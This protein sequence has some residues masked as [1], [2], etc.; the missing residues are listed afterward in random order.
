MSTMTVHAS[1]ACFPGYT[2]EDAMKALSA[3]VEEPLMGLLAVDQVQLC[4][5]NHGVLTGERLERLCQAYPDTRFRLHANCRVASGQPRWTAADVGPA[6]QAYFR[7]LGRLSRVLGAEAYTLHAGRRESSSLAGL[8]RKLS[9]LEQW[10]ELPV[11]V[12]GMYPAPG[13]KWLV[14]T[15]KEYRWLLASGV[16][17]AVDLS[18]LNIVARREGGLVDGL[19]ADLLESPRCIEVHVSANDG[20]RDSH[21]VPVKPPWWQAMLARA[22]AENPRLVI[23]SEG[24][25]LRSTR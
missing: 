4:P 17:Y 14:D 21:Q 13:A 1:A 18:H 15:S 24:N 8:Q 6:S 22:V 5:Q 2:P 25:Q 9:Q 10:M 7:E 23:F 20:R 12:E 19:V 3:G 16:K 11:G